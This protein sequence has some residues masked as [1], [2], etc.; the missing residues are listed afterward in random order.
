MSTFVAEYFIR[1]SYHPFQTVA[2]NWIERCMWRE[3]TKIV[4]DQHVSHFICY[5]LKFV[6]FFLFLFFCF[7]RIKEMWDDLTDFYL[8]LCWNILMDE[9]SFLSLII[10][11]LVKRILFV[12]GF[13]IKIQW[14][15]LK[16]NFL[17]FFDKERAREKKRRR[18]KK[19]W[20]I[21]KTYLQ[22]ADRF[23]NVC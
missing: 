5:A 11:E 14:I 12:L 15:N 10:L 2:F 18:G 7:L 6:D 1:L 4:M 22:K 8:L 20:K 23:A 3:G 19:G 13:S 17:L 9:I 21:F 16:R